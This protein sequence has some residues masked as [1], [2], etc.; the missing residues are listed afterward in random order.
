V[1]GLVPIPA[2]SESLL[3]PALLRVLDPVVLLVPDLALAPVQLLVLAE[4]LPSSAPSAGPRLFLVL[5]HRAFPVLDLLLLPV[6]TQCIPV[7]LPSAG[8]SAAQVLA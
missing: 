1:P 7:L 2:L 3:R 5:D 4:W 8:P 6:L